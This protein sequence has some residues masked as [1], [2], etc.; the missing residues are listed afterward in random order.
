MKPSKQVSL[1]VLIVIGIIVSL[2]R[3]TH[4]SRAETSW[5]VLGYYLPLP[6]CFIYHDPMLTKTDWL[7]KVNDERKLTGTLYMVSTNDKGEPMYFFLFGMALFYLPFF[8]I[9]HIF[10]SLS[11]IA[12]GFSLPYQYSLVIGGILYTLIGLFYLRKNLRYF[13]SER[14]TAIV[15]LII[16][17]STNYIHHMTLKDLETVNVIFML[18][19]IILWN[20]IKWHE[21]QKFRYLV[22]LG[23]AISLMGL[24]KPSEI[25][26]VLLPL[27]WN[28]KSWETFK[29]K[30][31]LIF[32][33]WKQLVITLIICLLIVLPQFL[34]WYAKTGSLIYDSYKNPGIGLDFSSPHIINALFSY[35]KGWL[36]YTP[37]MIFS[38]IGFYFIY[39][40][41]KKILLALAGYFLVSFY[42]ISCWTEWWYGAGFSNRPLIAIY[43]VLGISLGYF[44]QYLNKKGKIIKS[45]F[46]AILL[47][48]TFLNQFQWW[49]L[50]HYILDPYRTTKKY[51]WATFL[52]SSVPD[53]A[54]KF[55][56]VNRDFSGKM[57]FDNRSEYHPVF[58]QEVNF[59]EDAY[60]DGLMK[61]TINNSIYY[62]VPKSQEFAL[63]KQFIYK[64]LTS[65]DHLWTVISLNIKYPEKVKGAWPCLVTS[66]EHNGKSYGYYAC[67]IKTDTTN[68][69]WKEFKVEYLT[70][71]IRNVKDCLKV[72]LWNRDGDIFDIG[73]YKIEIFEKN[74]R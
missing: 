38:F 60:K 58:N 64:E 37:V 28:V 57:S 12:D 46:I 10:A 66:M 42:I 30:I 67:A 51:Y 1:L 59:K 41:N 3:I 6:A 27:L 47:F 63:T 68:K 48:F 70:P 71:E 53:N 34:Y 39:K 54:N 18:M 5:D 23:V 7:T 72:Y 50:K 33:N 49:Q 69:Q 24:V 52:R 62:H 16:V 21:N 14:I 32:E 74:S 43:P 31:L 26:I 61:D 13:F 8:F 4:V 15:M 55:L 19:N 65:K 11:G 56:L 35:R 45:I 29:G 17:F 36:L 9:G 44:L 25:I 73:Q 40:E 20:T 22:A 2:Y